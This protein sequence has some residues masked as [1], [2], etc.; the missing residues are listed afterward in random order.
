MVTGGDTKSGGSAFLA[1][2]ESNRM[3]AKLRPLFAMF[4]GDFNSD[5]GT[6]ES[7]WNDWLNNWSAQ[8]TT[9]DGRLTPLI[10]VHGNHENGDYTTINKLFDTPD[11]DS[12]LSYFSLTFADG[13]LHVIALNSELQNGDAPADSFQEQLAW[14]ES[15]LAA[16]QS[17]EFS[18]CR[19][20]QT[21]AATYL[22]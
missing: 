5:D 14:L 2:Q 22:K 1:G 8:T 13:L 18:N 16:S 7:Y 10:A 15:D 21:A 17:A 9:T 19:L 20:S 11:V 4:T 12:P 6:N 3:V